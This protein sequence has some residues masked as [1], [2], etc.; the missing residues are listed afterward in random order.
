MERA[1]TE[2]LADRGIDVA[3]YHDKGYLFAVVDVDIHYKKSAGLG[4][5]IDISTEMINMTNVTIALRH[6][7][8]RNDTLLAEANVR[9]ACINKKGK[10]QRI[11][12]SF[13]NIINVK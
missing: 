5:V 1:R 7:V 11:P 3:E 9:L 10:P 4:E 2:F 13:K 12:D 8:F 6:Q